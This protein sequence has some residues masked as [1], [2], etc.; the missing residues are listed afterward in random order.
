MARR[1][2]GEQYDIFFSY[3]HADKEAVKPLPCPHVGQTFGEFHH[4][5]RW[6]QLP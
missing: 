3:A 5:N 6:R 2:V 1:D 4:L